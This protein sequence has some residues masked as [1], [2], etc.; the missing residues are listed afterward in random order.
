MSSITS[1]A[2]RYS[3][4]VTESAELGNRTQQEGVARALH[5]YEWWRRLIYWTLMAQSERSGRRKH[6]MAKLVRC[7]ADVLRSLYEIHAY[8]SPDVILMI[9]IDASQGGNRAGEWVEN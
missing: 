4:C 9:R 7:V 6:F 2:T 5:S 1:G 3:L 8:A